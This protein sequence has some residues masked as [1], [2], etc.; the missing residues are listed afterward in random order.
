MS[1][2]EKA[3]SRR[4][5]LGMAVGVSGLTLCGDAALT[6]GQATAARVFTPSIILGPFYPQIKP[7]EQDAD[8][9]VLAG[10]Q[11]RAEGK[12]VYLSG[13]V[14]NLKGEPVSGAKISIWQANTYGRYSHKSDMNTAPLDPNFQGFGSR[15]TDAEGRYR[16]KTIKPG[17]YPAPVV[18]MRSP[19]VHFEVQAKYDR[20]ITQMFFPNEALNEQDHFLQFVKGS[21]REAVI[22]KPAPVN[23]G[24]GADTLS[25][26]WDIVLL[27]G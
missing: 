27:S 16:F 14:L 13:R 23:D 3:F 5:I 12:I 17:A 8:L 4:Q 19:H 6:F 22:A 10:R 21:Y 18:G 7:P 15:T 26:V 25:F 24:V 2:Q 1:K 11:R 9:T 20:L